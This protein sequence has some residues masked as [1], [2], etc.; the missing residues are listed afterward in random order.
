MQAAFKLGHKNYFEP[1][2]K[3]NFMLNDKQFQTN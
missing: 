1:T 2:I 3:K